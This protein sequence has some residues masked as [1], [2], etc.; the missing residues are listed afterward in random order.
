[1]AHAA[2]KAKSAETAAAL[3]NTT[4]SIAPIKPNT[5]IAEPATAKPADQGASGP[6]V[7]SGTQQKASENAPK[8]TVTIEPRTEKRVQAKP[9][10]KR[11]TKTA[12]EP[13]T[14]SFFPLF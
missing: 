14:K 13:E 7:Q 8:R 5:T 6:D 9:T 11:A 3:A 10:V 1:M 4:S 2:L 12:K